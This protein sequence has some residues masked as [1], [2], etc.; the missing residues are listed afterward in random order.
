LRTSDI[1]LVR[2]S[3]SRRT[4][5]AHIVFSQQKMAIKAGK[6]AIKNLKNSNYENISRFFSSACHCSCQW[7]RLAS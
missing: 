5:V 1:T 3:Q 2:N 6:S 4:I 7:L